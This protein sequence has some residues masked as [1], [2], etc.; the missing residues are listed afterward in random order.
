MLLARAINKV[1]HGNRRRNSSGSDPARMI[2]KPSQSGSVAT[3]VSSPNPWLPNWASVNHST[4]ATNARSVSRSRCLGVSLI[5]GTAL[6][7]TPHAPAPKPSTG[8]GPSSPGRTPSLRSAAGADLG[9]VAPEQHRQR[10]VEQQPRTPPG[11]GHRGE[12]VGAADEPRRE[13]AQPHPHQAR[14]ALVAAEA[15]HQPLGPVGERPRLTAAQ[16]RGDVAG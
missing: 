11:A 9:R 2:P 14:H 16:R 3:S 15:D 5:S 10:P 6:Q 4:T 1:G 12:V 13:P 8:G 7:R